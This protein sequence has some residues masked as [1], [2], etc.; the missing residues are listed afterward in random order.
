MASTIE[1]YNYDIFIS[2]RQKDNK[3]DRWV[4]EFVEALMTEL[5]STFKEEISVY[6]DI[7][8]HDGLL[9]TH[10]VD[11]SLKDKLK[12]LVFIPIVSRT[13][14]DPKSF[15]WEHEFKAFVE[16][17]SQDQFGLKVKLPN[18]NVASRVLPVRIYNLESTD[19]K[20]CESV[21]G[22]ALRGVEFIYSES[23]VNRPLKPD[24]DE[25]INLN[26]TKYRNQVNKVGNAIKEIVT[27][28]GQ[29]GQ[30]IEV[31]QK[32]IIESSAIHHKSNRT[33]IISGS[34]ILLALIVLGY[35][36]I[37]RM[38]NPP[39]QVEK[40]IAVLP[41][42]NDSPDSTNK[43]FI[44]GTMEAILDNL[45]KIAELTVISRTSVEQFRNTTKPI[46]EIANLL[47]VNYILEGSGQKYGNEIRLT[48]QLIDAVNDK[49]LWSSPYEGVTDNIFKLQS[50]IA[51]A[52]AS[53]LEAILT[54][55]EKKLIEKVPTQNMTAYDL[56]LRAKEYEE[57]YWKT[58]DSISY[59]KAATLY[60]TIIGLDSSFAKAY[61]GLARANFDRYYKE[62]YFKENFLDSCLILAKKA[63]SFDNN[64]D[65]AYFLISKYY[66]ANGQMD[67]ALDNIDKTLS[68]NPNFYS[69]FVVKGTILTSFQ[70]DY[71]KGIDN[72]NKALTLTRGEERPG[73][74]RGLGQTY[75]NVGFLEKAKSYYQEALDLD[76]NKLY[77]YWYFAWIEFCNENF[78]GAYK[79]VKERE[80]I[81]S[82]NYVEGMIP[83]YNFHFGHEE[84]AYLFA[85][86]LIEYFKKSG[87]MNLGEL[88]Q[89]GYAFWQVG[90]QKEAVDYFNQQIKYSEE[91]I[92]LERN[93]AQ[94]KSAQ[95]NL[96]S[97]YA[98]LGDKGK[99]YYYLDELNKSEFH[100]LVGIIKIKHDPMF[101]R[102]RSEER[103]Q[104]ILQNMEA[105][106]QAEHERVKKWL[107]EQ[108]TL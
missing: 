13:Y 49:H 14:C 23:G 104:K 66:Y 67:E 106:Y 7:N 89:I 70:H 64:L 100:S 47:N 19:I 78:E 60:K 46:R 18:G 20:L 102:I 40:S 50:Q 69:A 59:H 29:Q 36:F 24:D 15:A 22:G 58:L 98:F 83:I 43:Y 25:K 75:Q 72:Y 99:A 16:Q 77:T 53:N 63:L 27:A 41:F 65:E 48:V 28:L 81:D 57:E 52:I 71:V 84:E 93:S 31:R 76:N 1:G 79:L 87:A 62:T 95:Y 44:D 56:Y 54:P 55:G 42:R 4:S 105:K 108:G 30:K 103:F 86:K 91:S 37:P 2:Y 21:L 96:A 73:L 12:C 38:F 85:N 11:E 68:I 5:E 10:D 51:Q 45:C 61:T 80:K 17:A 32:E 9:E 92:R 97:T 33:K 90:K 82:A 34:I 39:E 74:L 94:T 8:P 26:K 3:G 35:F 6:F 88:N 101:E 107:E